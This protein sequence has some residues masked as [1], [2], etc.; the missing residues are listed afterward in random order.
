MVADGVGADSGWRDDV[1][2]KQCGLTGGA[3]KPGR[4][5]ASENVASNA[6]NRV[7]MVSPLGVDQAVARRE[8]PRPDGPRHGVALLVGSERAIEPCGGFAQRRDCVMQDG[9]VCLDLSDQMNA[10]YGSLLEC[11]F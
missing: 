5:G 8:R 7:D 4:D 9:L 1:A 2:D 11:F 10:A 3:P 6:D